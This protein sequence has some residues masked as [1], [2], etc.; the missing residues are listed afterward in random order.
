MD[1]YL[2]AIGGTGV[3]P[4]ACLLKEQGHRVRGSD[5]PLYPP[6]STLLETAGIEAHEGYNPA[7]L[8]PRPDLV[9]IGNAVPRTNPEAEEVERLGLE[10][11][12]MPEALYRFF[13]EGRRPLVVTGTHGKTT[14]T[15]MAAWVYLR[16]NADPGFLIGGLPKDLSRNFRAG[17]GARFIVEGDEYNAAYFDRGPKFFH[18]RPQTLILTSVEFDHADLYPD[19][20]AVE[21]VFGELVERLPQEALLIACGDSPDVR[22]VASRAKC[23]TISYG[24]DHA[25]DLHPTATPDTDADSTR[26][27]LIDPDDGEVTV[28]LSLAGHHNVQNALAVWAAAR[29][30][31]YPAETVAAALGSFGGVKRRLE[32]V[33]RPRGI[34][35]L[36]DFAHHPTAVAKTLEGLKA[37][38]PMR[39]LLVAFEPRS[40]TTARNLFFAEYCEAFKRADRVF[41]AP[42]YYAARI[43]AN[44][45]LDLAG[46][47]RNLAR[48][49]RPA[50]LT[51]G[52]DELLSRLADEAQPGDVIVTM[53]SGSFDGLPHRLAKALEEVTKTAP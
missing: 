12:S 33:G 5:G 44:E 20:E 40:L 36:D 35:V 39:R 25:N 13:L 21:R 10:R 14:T 37:R 2:I 28:R 4:L 46:I 15:A 38:F 1:I 8:D 41:F 18:Y 19:A 11:I 50:V 45:Q 23:K 47:S 51:T 43:E 31:G 24:L 32:L 27:E 16:C 42:I 22:R 29:A 9:I 49:G 6:M 53:S 17:G 48:S 30:D 7:H 26:F 34:A 52:I 3:A